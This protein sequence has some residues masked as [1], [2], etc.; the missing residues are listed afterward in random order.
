MLR[1]SCLLSLSR[2]DATFIR[3]AETIAAYGCT[4]CTVKGEDAI[5]E[6]FIGLRSNF[7]KRAKGRQIHYRKIGS[8]GNH[9]TLRVDPS[10]S[11]AVQ[12]HGP[13]DEAR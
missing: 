13:L 3:H 9:V 10:Y 1:D 12:P 2:L 8:D 5:A 11:R 6:E 7:Q 4:L